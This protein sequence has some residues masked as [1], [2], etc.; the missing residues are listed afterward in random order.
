[1][2][3][4]HHEDHRAQNGNRCGRSR[5]S[6]S[7]LDRRPTPSTC[8]WSRLVFSSSW[9]PRGGCMLPTS[10][11][12]SHA[13]S[14]TPLA[15]VE[16]FVLDEAGDDEAIVQMVRQQL[17]VVPDAG[18]P[19]VLQHG[20][21]VR[22]RHRRR[23]VRHDDDRGVGELLAQPRRHGLLGL[24]V[25]RR[26]RVVEHEHR[27]P[28][29][30][31]PREREALALAA[32]QAEPLLADRGVDAVGQLV[33]EVRL[34]DVERP[35]QIRLRAVLRPVGAPSSTLSRTDAEN[36]VASSNAIAT[37]VRSSLRVSARTSTPSIARRP[38]VTSKS[39]GTSAAI[40][41]FP[42]PVRPTSAMVSPGW[43]APGRRRTAG[44]R[45]RSARS[46]G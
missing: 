14:R 35:V 30:D 19:A 41:V 8:S 2:P 31:R 11:H 7:R 15:S 38:P 40:V 44:A 4:E 36:S 26:E 39:R 3:C 20:D 12:P 22:E 21:P 23:A 28:S 6:S 32:G 9:T 43:T 17:G 16:L 33:D 18:D 45:T 34:G 10:A 5:S 27:G 25:E 42:E 46:S 13:H 37:C 1:M 29:R 24:D